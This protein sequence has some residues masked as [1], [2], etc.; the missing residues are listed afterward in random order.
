VTNATQNQSEPIIADDVQAI[1]DTVRT[2]RKDQGLT[3]QEFADIVG[4]GVRFL[5]ELE[6]GKATAQIGL[7]LQVISGAGL[8]LTLRSRHWSLNDDDPDGEASQ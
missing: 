4:V 3:Q 6:R 5:S 2:A 7:V 1:G 8:E